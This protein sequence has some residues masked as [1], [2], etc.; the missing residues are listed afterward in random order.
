MVRTRSTLTCHLTVD[1]ATNHMQ[2]KRR[3]CVHDTQELITAKHSLSS[4]HYDHLPFKI[5]AICFFRYLKLGHL[6]LDCENWI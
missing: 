3:E 2:V 1:Y 5:E 4:T 6:F